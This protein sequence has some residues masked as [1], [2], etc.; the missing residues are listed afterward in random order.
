METVALVAA[1]LAFIAWRERQHALERA[2]FSR[3]GGKAPVPAPL[4]SSRRQRRGRKAK[5]HR[6]ISADD[7]AAFGAS[8]GWEDED[9]E[10]EPTPPAEEDED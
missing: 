10:P 8:R 9:D 4:G 2:A 6:V 3:R 7:D 1:F 5:Q